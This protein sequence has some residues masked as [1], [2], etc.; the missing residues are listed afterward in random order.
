MLLKKNEIDHIIFISAITRHSQV[1]H[2]YIHRSP[3]LKTRW[4]SSWCLQE[5]AG[6]HCGQHLSR[7][8]PGALQSQI[9]SLHVTTPSLQVHL[10]QGFSA[11]A[12]VSPFFTSWFSNQQ[13]INHTISLLLLYKYFSSSKPLKLDNGK[14]PR[15]II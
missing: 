1:W 5:A 11:G 9:G 6:S 12:R 10:L 3:L 4:W 8:L 13:P 14:I 15:I 2:W 7:W